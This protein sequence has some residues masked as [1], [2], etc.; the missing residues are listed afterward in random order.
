MAR[1]HNAHEREEEEAEEAGEKARD[2]EKRSAARGERQRRKQ[3]EGTCV[4]AI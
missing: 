2:G 1:S 3:M 4:T